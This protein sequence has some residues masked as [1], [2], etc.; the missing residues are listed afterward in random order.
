MHRFALFLLACCAFGEVKTLTLREA[1][2]LAMAQSPDVVLARLDQMKAREQVT[3]AKDPFM[4][5]VYMGSGAA[6]TSGFPASIE[7]SAPSI[8]NLK[9]QMAL[10]DRTQSYQV[11]QANENLRGM[12]IDVAKAQ[13][14]VAFRVASLFLDAEQAARSLKAAESESQNLERVLDYL[15]ARVA[16]G[17]ELPVTAHRADLALR[18]ARN[19]AENL[20]LDQAN[21]E[22]SLAVALGMKPDDRVR[23]SSEDRKPVTLPFS[24]DESVATAVNGSRDLK[25][26]ESNMQSK[27]L[28]IK[29]YKAQKL[30]KVNLVAQ[31]EIYAKYY[32]QNF[33]ST[34]QRFSGQLGASFE[35]PVLIGRSS[36]AYVR[37][38]EDDIAKIRVEMDRTRARLTAEVRRAYQDVKRAEIARD[39]AR[40][41]LD[42]AREQVSVDLARHD[43]GR[44]PI[45]ELEQSRATEQEKWLAYYEAQH[46]LER[47]RLNVMHQTGTLL[48]GLR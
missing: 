20:T 41:D 18:R 17:R 48:A 6:W 30:P 12:A 9:T 7:G 23:P 10:F 24:E 37:Q 26:L 27:M 16:D 32:Y 5:K 3:I 21:A 39:Y 33:F 45:S 35:V 46:T 2:D 19:A 25:R 11:A 22:T 40:E 29:G 36:A 42:V 43:E 4:P 34:F 44:A 15:K 13:D 31:T 8:L 38:S 28:E 47:A 1:L 14:E